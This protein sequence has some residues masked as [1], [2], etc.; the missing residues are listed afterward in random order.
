MAATTTWAPILRLAGSSPATPASQPSGFFFGTST[1][2][3]VDG[4]S[5]PSTSL[6]YDSAPQ[7]AT[8]TAS[9]AQSLPAVASSLA[10]QTD[11]TDL[12]PSISA[13]DMEGPLASEARNLASQPAPS[14]WGTAF[15][16][17]WFTMLLLLPRPG[18]LL[19]EVATLHVGLVALLLA[20]T[21]VHICLG[22]VPDK[23]EQ[24]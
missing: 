11:V 2:G 8:T 16:Q 1:P 14:G 19:Q 4:L 5:M 20:W 3:A 23:P 12:Q 24:E 18:V 7:P 21:S 15:L 17:V 22:L 13:A 9:L 6:A 10:A